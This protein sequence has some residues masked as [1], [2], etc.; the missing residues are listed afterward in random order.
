M[1]FTATQVRN[2]REVFIERL[3]EVLPAPQEVLRNKL[4]QGKISDDEYQHMMR[5]MERVRTHSIVFYE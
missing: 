3:E 1:A 5:V 4:A 2:L